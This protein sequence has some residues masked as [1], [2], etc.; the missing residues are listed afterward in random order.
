MS[1][2]THYQPTRAANGTWGFT[3][4]TGES[5]GFFSEPEARRAAERTEAA[6]RA[7]ALDGSGPFASILTRHFFP[8]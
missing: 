5:D 4:P 3:T 2:I 6:D 1:K 8:N 7:S